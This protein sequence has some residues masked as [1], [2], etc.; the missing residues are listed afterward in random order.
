MS[1]D[2]TGRQR[3]DAGRNI[4]IT[5]LSVCYYCKSKGLKEED[6]FCPNCGFPQRG[7]EQEMRKF[8]AEERSKQWLMQDHK[9]AV[10]KTRFVL[11][12][13]SA[14]YFILAVLMV[15][16]PGTNIFF[17]IIVFIFSGAF[18]GLGLWS[19][20]N[21]FSAT[22]AGFL[23]YALSLDIQTHIIPPSIFNG[24]VLKVII[25]LGLLYGAK[26]AKDASDLAKKLNNIKQ[27]KNVSD[28]GGEKPPMSN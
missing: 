4:V 9:E 18:L 24:T 20:K 27:S 15:V 22:L 1:K 5:D 17:S 12:G 19:K 26:T 2:L 8:L 28:V 14:L 16:S 7:T 11:F 25:F 3:D 21:P 6:K 23:V 13:L 10:N